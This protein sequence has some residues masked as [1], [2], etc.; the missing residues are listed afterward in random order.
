M[1][2]SDTILKDVGM[3][4]PTTSPFNN[5]EDTNILKNNCG[6]LINLIS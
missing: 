6:I 4:I 2:I 5:E 1:E 3:V